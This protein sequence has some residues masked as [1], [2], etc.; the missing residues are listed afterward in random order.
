MRASP[1]LTDAVARVLLHG[2][3]TMLPYLE[4]ALD[5]HRN[6]NRTQNIEALTLYSCVI[7]CIDS[8]RVVQF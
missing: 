3:Q 7:A 5:G 1:Y 2:Q 8:Y 4:N 6:D